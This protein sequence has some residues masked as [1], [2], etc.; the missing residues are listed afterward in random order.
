[1][2]P[3]E[4]GKGKQ[5]KEQHEISDS[6][7][8]L[9]SPLLGGDFVFVVR[10]PCYQQWPGRRSGRIG[11][12][13]WKS[14]DERGRR[15]G[16]NRH[17]WRATRDRWCSGPGR[18]CDRWVNPDNGRFSDWRVDTGDGRLSDRWNNCGTGR[19]S[20]R[21]VDC[22]HG[23]FSQRRVNAGDRRFSDWWVN[24]GSRRF[25]EQRGHVGNSRSHR[26]HG[27]QWRRQYRRGRGRGWRN[28]GFQ[29]W[30]CLHGR[31]SVCLHWRRREGDAIGHH[32]H[33]R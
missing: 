21:W 6:A 17:H 7:V 12:L 1:M 13:R 19:L 5:P 32:I 23:R 33:T 31:R 25:F 22:R 24:A 29:R 10:R 14:G 15:R 8:D 26:N 11:N 16:R 2:A 4:T 3:S 18:F 27:W 9:R 30:F 20:S 28:R